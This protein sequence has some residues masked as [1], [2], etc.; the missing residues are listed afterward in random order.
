MPERCHRLASHRLASKASLPS[1][2]LGCATFAI[3]TYALHC[4]SVDT[5]KN[6]AL[7]RSQVPNS[8][9]EWPAAAFG[10]TLVLNF[11]NL[12]FAQQL[13]RFTSNLLLLFINSVGFAT[14]CLIC[15]EA[16]PVWLAGNGRA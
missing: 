10:A 7:F 6:A 8:Y 11:M 9:V 16:T 13:T 5:E 2:S 14:N 1:L 15:F 12:A 3:S 4:L